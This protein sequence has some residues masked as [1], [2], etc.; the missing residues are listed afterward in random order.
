V[1][2]KGSA[3]SVQEILGYISVMAALEFTFFLMK[4]IMFCVK[5]NRGISLMGDMFISYDC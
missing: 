2:P 1:D 4:G 5:N 3:T